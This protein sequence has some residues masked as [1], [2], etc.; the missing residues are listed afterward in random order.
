MTLATLSIA[1]VS[2]TLVQSMVNPGLEALRRHV[3]TDQVGVS[4]VLTAFLLSS[5]VLTPVLGRL[6]DQVDKRNT[7]MAMLG[8]LAVG[9]IAA[10]AT[11]LPVLVVGRVVQG[12]GGVQHSRW[13]SVLSVTWC[14]GRRS[15]PLS[16]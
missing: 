3:H 8:V 14:P 9:V 6:G 15:G 10:L 13:P 7:M 1:T 12:A 4:W 5:A 11:S 16:G 2:Y